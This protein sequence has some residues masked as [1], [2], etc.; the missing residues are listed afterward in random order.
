[1][2]PV[3]HGE[4][5]SVFLADGYFTSGFTRIL[6]ILVIEMSLATV[7]FKTL[8]LIILMVNLKILKS[9]LY[10]YKWSFLITKSDKI[11]MN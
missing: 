7:C 4:Q 11:Y 10:V 8:P 9:V 6:L 2:L 1:M 3:F 5:N